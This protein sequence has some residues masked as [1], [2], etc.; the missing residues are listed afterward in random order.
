MAGK[1]K[2]QRLIVSVPTY[3]P[4]WLLLG[5]EQLRPLRVEGFQMQSEEKTEKQ[6]R[7]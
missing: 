3:L 7:H 1:F 2:V 5:Q 6:G 4:P